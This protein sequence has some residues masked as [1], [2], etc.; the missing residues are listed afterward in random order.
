MLGCK[1]DVQ[2]N[3]HTKR[4]EHCVYKVCKRRLDTTVV[5]TFIATVFLAVA[6]IVIVIFYELCGIPPEN[7]EYGL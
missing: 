3:K 2:S 5:W 1:E 4:F 7:C 6:A